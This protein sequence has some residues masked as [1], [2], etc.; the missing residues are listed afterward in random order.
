MRKIFAFVFWIFTTALYAANILFLIYLVGRTFSIPFLGGFSAWFTG[1]LGQYVT[2]VN[3]AG[4]KLWQ[5][6]LFYLFICTPVVAL[7]QYYGKNLGDKSV[8]FPL[9]K[10]LFGILA[11]ILKII[12][13]VALISAAIYLVFEFI[14]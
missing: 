5:L 2:F 6:W 7:L 13:A 4:F 3:I 12:I 14:I 10:T 9:L 11:G 1:L 8:N